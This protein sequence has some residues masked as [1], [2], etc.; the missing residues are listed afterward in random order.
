LNKNGQ[1]ARYYKYNQKLKY[2][3]LILGIFNSL[4]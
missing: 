2:V 4:S 3:F 1:L